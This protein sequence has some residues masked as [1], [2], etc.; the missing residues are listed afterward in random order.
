MNI[1][2]VH[3]NLP[4]QYIHL[5]RA[6]AKAKGVNLL[7]I[8]HGLTAQELSEEVSY[9]QYAITRRNTGGLLPLAKEI[10]TK[11]IRAEACAIKLNEIKK[12]GYQ[13]DMICAHP[14]WGEPLFVKDIWPNAPL[15]TY[16][17][18]SYKSI[19]SDLDFDP[20][21]KSCQEWTEKA[22]CRMKQANV[23]MSLEASDWCVTPTYFQKDTFPSAYKSKISVIHDG[24]NCQDAC[25]DLSAPEIKLITGQRLSRQNQL[26]TFVS[27]TLEPY[28]GIHSFIRSV[29]QIHERCPEAHVV[30]VGEAKGASYGFKCTTH[31]TWVE[32]FT[33]EIEGRY[34]VQRLHF[35]GPIPYKQFINLMQLS[36][37]HVYL[38]YPFVLSWS[39][40]EAMACGCAVVGSATEPVK[41]VIRHGQN[42]LLVDFFSPTQIATAVEELLKQPELIAKLG[43]QARQTIIKHYS[44][45]RCLPQQ[46]AIMDLVRNG[47]LN[48]ISYS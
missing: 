5:L 36:S 9:I 18:F 10:E 21:F 27:R 32:R 15:L 45:A 43:S 8:S 38:T 12:E 46:L 24:I 14:G 29:P 22:R 25:P 31:E 16:Q 39:M 11:I 20:E 47:T 34:D 7:G 13:P 40:L 44:L 3:H 6:M 41:E 42:G 26:I 30:V 1:L 28:R 48:A 4:S 19:D 35:L 2:F 33:A 37:V 17:E 23:L